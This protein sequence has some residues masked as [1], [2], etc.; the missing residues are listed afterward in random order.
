M[1]STAKRGPRPSAHNASERDLELAREREAVRPYVPCSGA[2]YHEW[3]RRG[4]AWAHSVHLRI[5]LHRFCNGLGD[6]VRALATE[7]L[8]HPRR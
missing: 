2:L 4:E 7:A 3:A 6:G 5:R 1:A 8:Q